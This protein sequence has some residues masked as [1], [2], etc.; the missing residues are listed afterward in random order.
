MAK[1]KGFKYRIYPTAE[2]KVFFAKS[3]GCARF[4]YN[5]MLS[6]KSAHYKENKESLSVTPAMYKKEFPWLKEVDSLALAN[7]QLNLDKAYKSFFSKR[8]GFPKFKSKK[9]YNKYTTN[10]QGGTI[11]VVS[12]FVKLP[13]IGYVKANFHRHLPQGSTIKSVTVS[14]SASGKYYCSI[15][16]QYEDAVAPNVVVSEETTLG[17]DYSSGSFYID[18]NGHSANYDKYYRKNEAK[19]ARAQRQLSRK[20]KGS[21]NRNKQRK[22]VAIIHEK[23]ANQRLDFCHK[24]SR[25][26][27]NSYN[28]VCIEDINLRGIAQSLKLGKA[29]NDNGFGLFRTLL[30][31]KLEEQGKTFVVINKWYAS[32]KICHVCGEKNSNLTLK[33]RSWTCES[34]NTN[35]DRDVNAAI[36]IKTEGLRQLKE[37]AIA[38]KKVKCSTVK[39]KKTNAA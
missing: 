37:E 35:H 14:M 15:L 1:N 34:C 8:S 9:V 33:D 20:K 5:K 29:T 27:A 23:T 12:D 22:K 16:V 3:F 28:C 25:E 38:I 32:T 6:D 36:N 31:Y 30:K 24:R 18:S 4:I 21:K 19:L 2:Q 17:L 7:V 10:N 13:K 11:S 26:I 39:K